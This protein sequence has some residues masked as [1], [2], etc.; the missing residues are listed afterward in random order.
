MRFCKA[1]LRFGIPFALIGLLLWF[2]THWLTH[3]VLNQ[4]Y[5]FDTRLNA[6]LDA[7]TRTQLTLVAPVT[8]IAVDRDEED[9]VLAVT[10]NVIQPSLKQLEFEFSIRD[11]DPVQAVLTEPLPMQSSVLER[12]IQ[13]HTSHEASHAE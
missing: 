13:S 10:L 2:S 8:S 3:S 6:G 9:A 11:R 4:A 1:K 7:D 12:L 5:N